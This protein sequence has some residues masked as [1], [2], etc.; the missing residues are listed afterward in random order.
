MWC[1]H[2]AVCINQQS[3]AA[4]RLLDW[5]RGFTVLHFNRELWMERRGDGR[6]EGGFGGAKE[7]GIKIFSEENEVMT[8]YPPGVCRAEGVSGRNCLGEGKANVSKESLSAYWVLSCLE[9]WAIEKEGGKGP[10]SSIECLNYFLLQQQKT[11][12]W[13]GSIIR[14]Q[15]KSAALI[16]AACSSLNGAGLSNYRLIPSY[17]ERRPAE[18]SM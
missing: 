9:V 17:F 10:K 18:T 2:S 3:P 6:E 12:P 4:S 1:T 11:Y 13:K 8:K 16:E 5:E 15:G 7:R 14:Y